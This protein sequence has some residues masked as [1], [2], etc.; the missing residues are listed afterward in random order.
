MVMW[1]I[2][3]IGLENR[4]MCKKN[5]P[6]HTPWPGLAPEAQKQTLYRNLLLHTKLK[7]NDK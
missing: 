5:M 2:K 6:G 1:H 4:T 3:L 7:G